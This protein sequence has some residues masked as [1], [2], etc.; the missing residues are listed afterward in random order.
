[1]NKHFKT[2]EKTSYLSYIF[3]IKFGLFFIPIHIFKICNKTKYL[4]HKLHSHE[5]LKVL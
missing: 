1:M 4:Q 3:L 5:A 2:Y